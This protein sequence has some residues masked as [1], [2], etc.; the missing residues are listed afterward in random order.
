MVRLLIPIE[1]SA[2]VL[3]VGR[4]T[5]YALMKAGELTTVKIGR[6]SLITAESLR[7]YVQRLKD[8]AGPPA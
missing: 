8:D 5:T 4:T 7:E 3:G 1:D 2:A 6:R